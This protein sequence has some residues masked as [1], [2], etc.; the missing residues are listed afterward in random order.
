MKDIGNKH[1]IST[2]S[3]LTYEEQLEKKFLDTRS[4]LIRFQKKRNL[5]EV[6]RS[7]ISIHKPR[8][9][10]CHNIHCGDKHREREALGNPWNQSPVNQLTPA[11][12]LLPLT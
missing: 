5:K 3:L 1:I 10:Y 12:M 9:T 8:D 7:L 6:C 4:E 2:P 11:Q